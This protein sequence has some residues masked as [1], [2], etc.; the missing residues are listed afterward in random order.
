M[1]QGLDCSGIRISLPY[2]LDPPHTDV[3]RYLLSDFLSDIVKDPIS[4]ID[5]IAQPKHAHRCVVSRGI[6]RKDSLASYTRICIVTRRQQRGIFCGPAP[7]H[8][9]Q[10]IHASCG[11]NHNSTLCKVFR[12]DSRNQC[13]HCPGHFGLARSAKLL[14][15]HVDHIGHLWKLL[16]RFSRK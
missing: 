7:F 10:W 12:C 2:P 3:D 6:V 15:C 11:E 9:H 13:V 16:H 8:W 4:Q 14:P 1:S 5:G